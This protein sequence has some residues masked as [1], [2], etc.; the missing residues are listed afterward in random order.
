MQGGVSGPNKANSSYL[1]I[2]LHH[3]ICLAPRSSSNFFLLLSIDDDD[4]LEELVMAFLLAT[5]ICNSAF[6]TS[7]LVSTAVVSVSS[8]TFQVGVREVG[9]NLQEMRQK[10]TMAGLK[11]TGFMSVILCVNF[12]YQ[13]DSVLV[14]NYTDYTNCNTSNPISKFEDGNT[15][16]RFDGHGVFYFISGQPDHCQSGQKLIIRVMAQSEVKP[17]EP[18]PSPKTDGSAFSPE[19]LMY[20]H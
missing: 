5:K 15:L 19:A 2:A 9:P 17:P 8:Y 14:V 11:R 20:L 7:L 10:L 6:F 18:A 12:K 4:M 13:Q 3:I 1:K 16:F